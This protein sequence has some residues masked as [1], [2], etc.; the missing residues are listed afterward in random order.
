MT[1]PPTDVCFMACQPVGEDWLREK[2][3]IVAFPEVSI[4]GHTI[5]RFTKEHYREDLHVIMNQRV[6]GY[7]WGC[8]H[9]VMC[10]DGEVGSQPVEI[11]A[12][13][14]PQ[15]FQNARANAWPDAEFI[16]TPDP[17]SRIYADDGTGRMTEVWNSQD[18]E[19]GAG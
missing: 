4:Y 18:G 15:V 7:E 2:F 10:P 14:S 9:S 1:Q 12:S 3:Y 19:K 6:A 5:D 16:T 17:V 11:C 8:W 13:V